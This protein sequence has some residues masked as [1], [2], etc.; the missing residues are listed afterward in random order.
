MSIIA[1]K[2]GKTQ[3]NTERL[4]DT[5]S[6]VLGA[7]AFGN[8]G[9][10]FSMESIDAATQEEMVRD[11]EE[12]TSAVTE[13]AEETETELTPAQIDAAE[14]AAI[15]A[16]AR[17]EFLRATDAELPASS[18]RGIVVRAD[19]AL[20]GSSTVGRS[21]A[22][23]EAY[24]ET[25]NRNT[26]LNSITYNLKAARQDEFGEELFPT[27]TLQPDQATVTVAADLLNVSEDYQRRLGS[28]YK[29]LFGAQNVI[30]ALID[31]TILNNDTSK[32]IPVYRDGEVKSTV[33]F[34]DPADVAPDDI[35]LENGEKVKTAP[36][37]FG[38]RIELL[39]QSATD[40][41][42]KAGV[43]DRTDQLDTSVVLRTLYMKVKGEVFAFRHLDMLPEAT[44]AYAPAG[45]NRQ[46]NL[47]FTVDNLGIDENTKL[48]NGSDSTALASIK[49][50]KQ[51]VQLSLSAFGTV[52]LNDGWLNL[53]AGG[54]SVYQAFNVDGE[55]LDLDT[56]D[57]KAIV[58]LFEDAELIGFDINAR[59]INTNRR[60]RGQ[61]LDLN[62]ERMI[63]AMPI[64]APISYVRPVTEG[65]TSDASRLDALVTTTYARCSAAAVSTLLRAEEYLKQLPV[66]HTPSDLYSQT[67][68]GM[69]RFFVT[70]HYEHVKLDVKAALNTLRSA[71]RIV[72]VQ[73]V[74]VNVIRELVYKAHYV[75]GYKAASDVLYGPSTKKPLVIVATDPYIAN[76]LMVQGDWRTLGNEF[77]MKVVSTNNQDMKGK[78]RIVFGKT[79]QAA[80]DMT[81]P[82][83]FGNM[84]WRPE[85]ATVLPISR[86]NTISKELTVQPSFLHVVH[87][88]IMCSIDVTNLDTAVRDMVPVF[89]KTV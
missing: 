22:A 66:N 72:D 62:R 32:C 25:E 29:K 82:L 13:F 86:N 64:L 89:T 38:R 14:G 46:M 54:V 43:L 27:V 79:S 47:T 20:G 3:T 42:L 18:E 36:L 23:L 69:G 75:S 85:L 55:K 50:S 70:P 65:D 61:L 1:R 88:P 10:Y 52:N 26:L 83:H 5:V 76:Y 11:G 60:E 80:D 35:E 81:N 53:T 33:N 7:N 37:V 24:D 16:S 45:N 40:A 8:S 21:Q 44:F 78:I 19:G 28:E 49:T 77:E 67:V 12:L 48:A 59:R 57:G 74:L 84:Y 51:T 58:D 15:A 34:V 30:R 63:Y 39:E 6:R 73:A 56:G 87:C 17:G 71:D 68:L 41:L 31:P 2:F 9:R 4:M